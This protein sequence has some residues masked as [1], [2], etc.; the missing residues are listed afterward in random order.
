VLFLA[1]FVAFIFVAPIFERIPLFFAFRCLRHFRRRQLPMVMVVTLGKCLIAIELTTISST[2]AGVLAATT[3]AA[4]PA[5]V[6][7]GAAGAAIVITVPQTSEIR[8]R[9]NHL[10]RQQL[11]SLF[12]FPLLPLLSVGLIVVLSV[13]PTQVSGVGIVVVV[14]ERRQ[15]LIGRIAKTFSNRLQSR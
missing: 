7:T 15:L 12:S 3:G 9:R 10:M 1:L 4:A 2:T 14:F 5:A 11:P 13:E 8:R 6:G